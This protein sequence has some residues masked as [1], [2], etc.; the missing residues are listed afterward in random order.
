MIKSGILRAIVMIVRT[1]EIMA[2]LSLIVGVLLNFANVV[3]R[4]VFSA[5]IPW[6]EEVMVFL[7]IAGVFLGAGAI[8]LSGAHIRMDLAVQFLSPRM[9]RI[10][11]VV[12][13][14]GF[15]VTATALIW[16]AYPVIA[17]L[18][19]FDQRSEA[20]RIPVAFPHSVVPIGLGI[21][22]LAAIARLIDAKVA[23]LSPGIPEDIEADL[24]PGRQQ[25]PVA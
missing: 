24:A 4:Y 13:H 14:V 21:M 18:Y 9:Q 2:A 25:K 7:M 10:L 12:A 19:A 23:G 8:T 1:A 5:P 16:I 22:I 15:I 3:G 6:A 11:D 20:I 17:Q